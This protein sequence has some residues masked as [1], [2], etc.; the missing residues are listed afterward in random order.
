MIPAPAQLNLTLRDPRWRPLADTDGVK[1]ALDI[2]AEDV[3]QLI[4]LGSLVAFNIAVERHGRR[5][6]RFLTRSIEHYRATLGSRQLE[7]SWPEMFRLIAPHDKPVLVGTEVD[8]AL[9]CD[10]DH[11]LNLARAN[12]LETT[13][14]WRPGRN[15]APAITRGSFETFLKTRLL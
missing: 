2:S 10:P 3:E 7:L 14:G 11:R 15:G 8:A 9:N 13:N 4:D 6:L 1:W 5:E 12:L